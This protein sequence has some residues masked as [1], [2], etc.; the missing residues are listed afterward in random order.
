MVGKLGNKFAPII[1]AKRGWGPVSQ[2]LALKS[3][4]Y[5]ANILVYSYMVNDIEDSKSL[6]HKASDLSAPKWGSWYIANSY[7]IN[8]IYWRYLRSSYSSLRSNYWLALENAFKDPKTFKDHK[9]KLL[10]LIKE[11]ERVSDY[12]IAV[13]FPGTM[14]VNQSKMILKKVESVFANKNIP[15]INLANELDGWKQFDLIV[16]S[17]DG[18]PS[19]KLHA[20]VANRLLAKLASHMNTNIVKK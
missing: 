12:S 3:F 2:T 11:G 16:N 10:N 4:P 1:L 8:F 14:H 5:K 6:F 17:L 7:L 19:K 13:L 20:F 18:H 9:N 15:V